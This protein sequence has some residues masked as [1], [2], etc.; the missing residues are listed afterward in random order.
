VNVDGLELE[1]IP[2][3]EFLADFFTPEPGQSVA[4]VGPTGCGKTTIGIQILAIYTALYPYLTGVALVMKP[5]KGPKS[6][7]RKSTGDPTVESLTRKFGGRITRTWPPMKRWWHR[8]KPAFWALWPKST[9]DPQKDA[10]DHYVVFRKCI[11]DSYNDGDSVVFA[12]EAAGLSDDLE[13]EEELKQTLSRG[14]SMNAAAILA[15]QRPRYVTRSMFSE[16]KH[17]LLWKMADLGE[18]ERLR[19]IGGGQLTRQQIVAVLQKLK[20]HQC[21]YLYPDEGI[22]CILT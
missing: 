21:L 18:Y 13:L 10:A 9:G 5:H 14:R 11:L 20:K 19:E 17:F 1:E 15:T 3:K 12:D 8:K 4:L 16:S 7:G 6:R 2:I 22:A